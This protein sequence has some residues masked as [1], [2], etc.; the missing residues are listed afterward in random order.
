M[1]KIIDDDFKL[2]NE[3]EQ[4]C[5]IDSFGTRI[6]SHFLCYGYDLSFVDFWVQI[7]NDVITS[8]FC[9]LDGEMVVC[10][11]E[12]SDLDEILSFLNF[13]EKTTVTFDAL[14][15]DVFAKLSEKHFFGDILEYKKSDKIPDTYKLCTPEI[16]D[17][18]NLLLTCKSDDFFVS[19]YPYFLSD[20]TR[21][22]NR[23]MCEIFGI[24]QDDVLVS[25]AMNVSFTNS[26][27]ILGAVATHPMHR[28]H[29]YAGFIV[30]KLAQHFSDKK[31]YIY[32]TIEKNTR[33]YEKLGFDVVGRWVK[34][35]FGG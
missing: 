22:L 28:K 30:T 7:T 9:K 33:F 20:V 4:F 17:Y 34:Y 21:R 16:K 24:Y 25:C 11:S 3:F 18:H 23:D 5:K 19:D 14:Y 2:F 31:V 15:A 13:Q 29:G 32:T 1:I 8:A 26:S 10:I 12:N 6:Y 35:T 27:V